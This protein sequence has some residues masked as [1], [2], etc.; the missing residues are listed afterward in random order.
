[1]ARR[2]LPIA[3]ALCAILV[4]GAAAAQREVV[5][6]TDAMLEDPDPACILGGLSRH[7]QTRQARVALVNA[8]GFGSNNAAVVLKKISA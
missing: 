2:R 6:V 7:R 1:M 8:F 4:A 3:T 5:P